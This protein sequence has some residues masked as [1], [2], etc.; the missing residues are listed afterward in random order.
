[1]L[2]RHRLRCC[3]LCPDIDDEPRLV[4]E[5]FSTVRAHPTTIL[6]KDFP[7]RVCV[8][9]F[10]PRGCQTKQ[11]FCRNFCKF[12]LLVAAIGSF[13]IDAKVVPEL[14]IMVARRTCW[15]PSEKY[16]GGTSVTNRAGSIGT[17]LDPFH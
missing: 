15:R 3:W 10:E 7:S 1:M 11:R 5:H 17:F 14:A 16:F 9:D 4:I 6:R 8:L 13:I 12:P 2:R